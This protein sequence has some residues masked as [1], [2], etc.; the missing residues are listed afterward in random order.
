M[1]DVT[2]TLPVWLP[3]ANLA[4]GLTSLAA[5]VF[6]TV[7]AIRRGQLRET[8]AIVIT[9]FVWAAVLVIVGGSMS[10]LGL[11]SVEVWTIVGT[12]GRIILAV[13]LLTVATLPADDT[14]PGTPESPG[15]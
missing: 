7:R 8:R 12:G 3:L 15:K 9:I 14:L 11:M 4:L 2:V 5:L 1:T 13:G 6:L 10:Q